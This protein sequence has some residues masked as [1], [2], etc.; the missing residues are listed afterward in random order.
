MVNM[1][2]RNVL[3]GIDGEAMPSELDVASRIAPQP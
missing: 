3:A 1:A 2:A